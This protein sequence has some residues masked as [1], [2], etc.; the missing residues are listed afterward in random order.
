M[1]DFILVFGMCFGLPIIMQLA[2]VFD[3]IE[4][5]PCPINELDG[6]AF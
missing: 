5:V 3:P 4:V 1:S 2:G 6:S